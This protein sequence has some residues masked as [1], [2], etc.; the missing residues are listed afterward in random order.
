MDSWNYVYEN[1]SKKTLQMA[2]LSCA[3][4]VCC[5]CL[6]T[7]T[8]L[9]IDF[10]TAN[11]ASK[12]PFFALKGTHAMHENIYRY[13]LKKFL[14]IVFLAVTRGCIFCAESI[15]ARFC[16]GFGVLKDRKN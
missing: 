12:R 10:E 1:I 5:Y 11:L 9:L 16:N 8:N 3:L 7:S 6:S 2:A 14:E 4:V 13:F 15:L